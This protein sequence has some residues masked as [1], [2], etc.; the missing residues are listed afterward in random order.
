MGYNIAYQVRVIN[1]RESEYLDFS[2]KCIEIARNYGCS[3]HGNYSLTNANVFPGSFHLFGGIKEAASFR[4][5][6]LKK[7]ISNVVQLEKI[8]YGKGED[9]SKREDGS[10][11]EDGSKREKALMTKEENKIWSDIG[12][13]Y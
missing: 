5:E 9:G 1:Q 13:N 10:K 7:G 8:L 11:L 4:D 2:E 6:I 3:Y 12:K